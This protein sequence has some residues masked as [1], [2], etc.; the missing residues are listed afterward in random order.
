MSSDPRD[1]KIELSSP[2]E[3]AGAPSASAPAQ[4]R[5]YLSVHFA[6]CG[7]YQRVYRDNDGK[8][9]RGRC[10]RCAKLVTFAVGAGGTDS[11]SF[12]VY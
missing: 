9:Y 10:P 3:G 5:P 12:V 4:P 11:R 8:T 2:P 6:C 7:I 1:Y